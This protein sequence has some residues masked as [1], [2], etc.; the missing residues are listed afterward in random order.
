M[1]LEDQKA[2]CET[3]KPPSKLE[4]LENMLDAAVDKQQEC[5]RWKWKFTLNGLD[6][7]LADHAANVIH[8]LKKFKEV[9][10]VAVNYDPVHAA[11]PWAGVRFLLHVRQNS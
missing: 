1:P 11:L 4:L 2:I 6:V 10:D 5:D 8:W 7:V 3:P 9:G